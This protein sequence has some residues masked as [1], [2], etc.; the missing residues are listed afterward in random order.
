MFCL[1]SDFYFIFLQILKDELWLNP[2]QFFLLPEV[3]EEGDDDEE[4]DDD[5][6]ESADE[7]DEANAEENDEA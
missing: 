3:E 6:G 4:I 2:L 5:Q 1:C 7:E